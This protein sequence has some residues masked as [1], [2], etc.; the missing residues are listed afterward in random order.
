M[1]SCR[2]ISRAN[3]L[4]LQGYRHACHVMLHTAIPDEVK[5]FGYYPIK[6]STLM[7]FR[8]DGRLGFPGG[9]VDENESLEEAV[10]RELKE[11][12]GPTSE[13]VSITTDNYVI[14][15]LYE[16]F[17]A[18][19]KVTKRLCLHFFTKKVSVKQFLELETR[20]GSQPNLGFEVL[21]IV[22]CPVYTLTD[23]EGGFPSFLRNNFVGN[24]REQLLIGIAKENLLTSQEI[25]EA[26]AKS[27][28]DIDFSIA[29]L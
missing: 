1:S 12:M 21:G 6:H 23:K 13:P 10:N 27:G 25:H 14:T 17:I 19:M 20:C 2:V 9:F 11:E 18:E 4:A 15:H 16:Q 29:K 7:Q 8:F 5:L 28:V 26:I 3:S 22:R 24:A